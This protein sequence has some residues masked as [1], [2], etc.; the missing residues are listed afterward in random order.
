MPSIE[1]AVRQVEKIRAKSIISGI[2]DKTFLDLSEAANPLRFI[3]QAAVKIH[4]ELFMEFVDRCRDYEP[5]RATIGDVSGL[6][7]GRQLLTNDVELLKEAMSTGAEIGFNIGNNDPFESRFSN[8]AKDLALDPNGE[9]YKRVSKR[10]DTLKK[11]AWNEGE[12][13]DSYDTTSQG[14]VESRK[15]FASQAESLGF[16]ETKVAKTTEEP[17]NVWFADGGMGA[18][19]RTWRT[20]NS[21]YWHNEKRH[22]N[23]LAPSVCFKMAINSADQHLMNVNTVKVDDLPNQELTAERLRNYLDSGNP[24]PDVLY[25]TPADN[26]TARSVDPIKFKELLLEAKKANPNIVFV[27]DM[28][29]MKLIPESKAKEITKAITES[30]AEKQAIFAWSDSKRLGRPRARFGAAIIYE[31]IKFLD[32]ED[33]KEKGLQEFFQKDATR[34]FPSYNIDS[35]L[36]YQALNQEIDQTV[37]FQY[38]ELLRQRQRALLEVLSDLDPKRE[39]F[40]NLD[41]IVILDENGEI[42]EELPDNASIQDVPLYLWPE[43][44]HNPAK[45]EFLRKCFDIFKDEEIIGAPGTIFGDPNHMRFSLGVIS[46]FDILKKSPKALA[47]WINKNN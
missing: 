45:N 30:G 11:K 42:P 25:L 34:C 40:K 22:A 23:L 2:L 14:S 41:S 9:T 5:L 44:N 4:R 35:D 12:A 47:R 26:P 8:L 32:A 20:L 7:M 33:G 18:L 37:L 15:I 27:F 19:N 43:V 16:A 28:A 6:T 29:Y 39:Y 10:V 31:G 21:L 13:L 1:P 36:I 17:N 38:N 3:E 46:T 24:M